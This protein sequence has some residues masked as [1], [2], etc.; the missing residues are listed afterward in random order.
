MQI[1]YGRALGTKA[2]MLGREKALD[3]SVGKELC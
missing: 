3:L 2:R 1:H